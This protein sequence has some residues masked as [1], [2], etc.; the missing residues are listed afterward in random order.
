[1]IG[2]VGN[3]G[4][5]VRERVG[6][7]VD[8]LRVRTCDRCV[9]AVDQHIAGTGYDTAPCTEDTYIERVSEW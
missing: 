5:W 7:W 4:R 3:V 2:Y 9:Q 8:E 1:M 6:E